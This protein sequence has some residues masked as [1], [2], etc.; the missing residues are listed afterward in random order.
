MI[1]FSSM[2]SSIGILW[3]LHPAVF[4]LIYQ[5]PIGQ[6]MFECYWI[7]SMTNYNFKKP[8]VSLKGKIARMHNTSLEEQ[9]HLKPC[10]LSDLAHISP[11]CVVYFIT[12]S[13]LL[14]QNAHSFL[15]SCSTQF[16]GGEAAASSNIVFTASST[17]H[18]NVRG[19]G[20]GLEIEKYALF[21]RVVKISPPFLF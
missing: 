14:P 10:F 7:P 13:N 9:T 12:C 5:L 15:K 1:I 6:G 4:L 16:A 3:F 20:V 21:I 2:G 18:Y 8:A 17:L 19:N 11:V